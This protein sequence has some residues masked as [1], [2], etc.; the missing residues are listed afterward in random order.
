MVAERCKPRSFAAIGR[1]I[2]TMF[3]A[4]M[5]TQP[6]FCGA[7]SSAM[8]PGATTTIAGTQIAGRDWLSQL[9][10]INAVAGCFANQNDLERR[11]LTSCLK[12][13]YV[14]FATCML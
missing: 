12:S 13:V 14:V 3:N 1:A 2:A 11:A 10:S 8:L 7:D 6:R 4:A 9:I 5:L